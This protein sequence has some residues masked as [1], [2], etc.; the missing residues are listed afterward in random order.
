MAEYERGSSVVARVLGQNHCLEAL[1]LF[2]WWLVFD[3]KEIGGDLMILH[4][5][6]FRV[7]LLSS[8]SLSLEVSLYKSVGLSC[9]FYFPSSSHSN[10][11]ASHYTIITH[12]HTSTSSNTIASKHI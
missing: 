3:N 1:W 6:Y 11:K 5:V 2:M 10:Y 4:R 7:V 8:E 12:S 9:L